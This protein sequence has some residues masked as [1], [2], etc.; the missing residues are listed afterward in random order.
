MTLRD[1]IQYT[2]SN[3]SQG[4]KSNPEYNSPRGIARLTISTYLQSGNGVKVPGTCVPTGCTAAHVHPLYHFHCSFS[5]W[6]N[7]GRS[8]WIW[9]CVRPDDQ[10]T[11]L[12]IRTLGREC[13]RVPPDG[14]LVDDLWSP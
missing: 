4:L 1:E 13:L 10:Y 14:V 5:S 11:T 2:Y 7:P 3:V 9:A 6:R 8:D 12:A